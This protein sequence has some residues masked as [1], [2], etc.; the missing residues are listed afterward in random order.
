VT[1]SG[2]SGSV[3]VRVPGAK[4]AV[5]VTATSAVPV[6]SVVD[7]RQGSVVLQ[8]AVAGAKTQ[9]ATIHGGVFQVVQSATK[10]GLTDL[11][12]R[13]PAPSCKAGGARAAAVTKK[14]TKARSLWA[15][16]NH[17]RFR[18][19]GSNAVATVR[20]TSWYMS[21]RCDGTYTHVSRGVVSVFDLHTRRS[22]VLHA[23]QSHLA[24]PA[25]H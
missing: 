10:G 14:R 16:D 8:T 17:G 9:A 7:T 6:G 15:S 25:H 4:A 22:Y 2:K 21:E 24:R 20:G 19:R 3:M 5:P 18:T 11:V 12:L 23:G 13:G 1:V